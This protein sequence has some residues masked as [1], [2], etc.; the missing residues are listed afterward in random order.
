MTQHFGLRRLSMLL[1]GMTLFWVIFVLL[2]KMV[3]SLNGIHTRSWIRDNYLFRA[4]APCDLCDSNHKKKIPKI[5][6]QIWSDEVLPSA[7]VDNVRDLVGNHPDWEYYFWTD[8]AGQK[9]IEDRY[10]FLLDI[11]KAGDFEMERFFLSLTHTAPSRTSVLFN[12]LPSDKKHGFVCIASIRRRK[13]H[14]GSSSAIFF[15]QI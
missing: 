8:E 10:S 13:F 15:K 12:P 7:M 5:I 1:V 6:H 2:R 3:V 4:I 14:Y 9:L 11:Y